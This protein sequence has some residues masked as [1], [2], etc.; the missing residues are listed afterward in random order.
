MNDSISVAEFYGLDAAILVRALQV[1]ESQG[2]A[3][4]IPSDVQ[5]EVGVKFLPL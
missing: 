5:D 3:S 2:K 4:L 1:L